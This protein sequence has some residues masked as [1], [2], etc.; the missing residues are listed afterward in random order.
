M[1]GVTNVDRKLRATT[2]D[3]MKLRSELCTVY[4]QTHTA[5]E[6]MAHIYSHHERMGL[7]YT[8]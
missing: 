2:L 8:L 5:G 7:I 1:Q 3:V 6:F 4:I